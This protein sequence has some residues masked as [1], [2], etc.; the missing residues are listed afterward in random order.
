MFAV[1]PPR[2]DKLELIFEAYYTMITSSQET[3]SLA[4]TPVSG[5]HENIRNH[6]NQAHE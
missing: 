5:D 4:F 1:L 3:S 2:G 6:P